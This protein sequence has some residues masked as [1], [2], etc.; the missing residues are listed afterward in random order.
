MPS[1]IVARSVMKEEEISNALM[2]SKQEIQVEK[3][4]EAS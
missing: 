2:V 3:K 1:M 4:E